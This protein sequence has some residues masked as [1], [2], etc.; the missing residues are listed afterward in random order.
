[1]SVEQAEQGILV[2]TAPN[3]SSINLFVI[4]DSLSAFQLV[5]FY[6]TYSPQNNIDGRPVAQ[7]N[8]VLLQPTPTPKLPNEVSSRIPPLFS[9]GGRVALL[10]IVEFGPIG[11][12]NVTEVLGN[13]VETISVSKT[14]AQWL[15]GVPVLIANSDL[16]KNF[17]APGNFVGIALNLNNGGFAYL[18]F[19]G[20]ISR[21]GALFNSSVGNVRA[22]A[23]VLSSDFIPVFGN[24]TARS[25]LLYLSN[26]LTDGSF[27]LF[28]RSCR[29]E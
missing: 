17:P 9:S 29:W 10:H 14:A 23:A 8:T 7:N 20:N 6:D 21:Q 15:Q 2:P 16:A 11:S 24:R 27:L 5:R 19:G 3:A 13:G 26:M 25:A 18:T 1:M 4:S 28:F 22:P 12:V